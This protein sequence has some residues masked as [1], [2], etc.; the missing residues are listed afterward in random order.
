MKILFYILLLIFN[1]KSI[2]A[3]DNW[4][5]EKASNVEDPGYYEENT[6]SKY[7]SEIMDLDFEAP[8]IKPPSPEFDNSMLIHRLDQLEKEVAS[9]KLMI[10]S[11]NLPKNEQRHNLKSEASPEFSDH[12]ATT[13]PSHSPEKHS[14]DHAL[15]LLKEKKFEESESA[16]AD[17]IQ[18]YPKSDL[19]SNSYFWYGETFFQRQNYEKSALF[20]LKGYKLQPKGS[21]AADSLLKL[22]LSLGEINKK[23]EAC[24]ML[25]KLEKEF[26]KRSASSK[27]RSN[28]AANKF[29]C[30]IEEAPREAITEDASSEE[31]KAEEVIKA[32]IPKPA[33]KAAPKASKPDKPKESKPSKSQNNKATQ[34]IPNKN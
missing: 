28:E 13:V 3:E 11:L 32:P 14:Y 8:D 34:N 27:K 19:Q 22:A 29:G 1:I 30:V 26:P 7:N 16:F 4:G 6:S 21:K 10:Q 2:Y 5:E 18:K 24:S 9:I 25:N 20:Y 31:P 12:T 17:F 23:K 33:P 15:S